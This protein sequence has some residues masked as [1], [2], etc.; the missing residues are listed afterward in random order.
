MFTASTPDAYSGECAGWSATDHMETPLVL[1]VAERAYVLA[2]ASH[3]V[4]RLTDGAG[5][6]DKNGNWSVSRRLISLRT[7]HHQETN[8]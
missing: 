1:R 6:A 8:L 7:P 5:L 3:T 4:P 2:D